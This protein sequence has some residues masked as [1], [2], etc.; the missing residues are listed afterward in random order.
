MYVL[1]GDGLRVAGLWGG[2]EVEEESG[3]R[4]WEFGVGCGSL[5]EVGGEGCVGVGGSGG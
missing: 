4:S 3:R 1:S 5:A 2:L